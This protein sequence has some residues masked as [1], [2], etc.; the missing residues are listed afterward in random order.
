VQAF[1]RHAEGEQLVEQGVE[2]L[3]VL[4]GAG[5]R[6]AKHAG[7]IG[8]GSTPFSLPSFPASRGS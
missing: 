4:V 6:V 2:E 3:A 1:D 8:V 5:E 7:V